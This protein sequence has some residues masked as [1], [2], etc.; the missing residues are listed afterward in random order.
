MSVKRLNFSA[1]SPT[2]GIRAVVGIIAI[3]AL[4]A[5]V[6]LAS[7]VVRVLYAGSL[8]TLMEHDIGPAFE[9][10]SGD[11]F[12]G[13]AG[14]SNKLAN[15][16]KGKVR[17]GDVFV[18]A[19]PKVDDSLM[20]PANGNWVSWYIAFAQ[21]P[22]V[23][24]YSPQSR[25]AA[26]FKTKPWYEVLQE[27]GIRIGRTDPKLDPKGRLTLELMEKAEAAYHLPGLAHKVLRDDENSAQ[28]LPEEELVGRL[29]S[30][31]VDVGFFYS[32][33]T[34]D[35]HIPAIA[36]P[37][38]IAPKAIYTVTVLKDAPN[39][40]GAEAFASYLLG[41]SGEDVLKAH[42]LTL[43]L[44]TLSGSAEDVPADLRKR[45]ATDK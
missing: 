44:P 15:E 9:K 6:A 18:S 26:D 38:A 14:G 41:P 10:A 33:E 35:A 42:G 20:G 28:V 43:I 23:I 5:N 39:A 24:G 4:G 27:P 31:Q 36:L 8:V 34:A 13:Y 12:V 2:R 19:N 40:R 1:K 17:Q 32:T 16:I 22:L 21:S 25:L 37:P 29:Q 3:V 30:G 45:L 11:G 7:G